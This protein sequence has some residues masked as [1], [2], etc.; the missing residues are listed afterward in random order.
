MNMRAIY[1]LFFSAMAATAAVFAAPEK[2]ASVPVYK[3]VSGDKLKVMVVG[4]SELGA[5]SQPIDLDGNVGLPH[6]TQPV[7]VAGLSAA[8]AEAAI[9][10]AYTKAAVVPDPKVQIN[11]AQ[12]APR[13]IP[14]AARLS[15]P[16]LS[17]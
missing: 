7:H 5:A 17:P 15:L 4:H 2:P 6:L 11:V 1:A 13:K 9:A 10:G 3:L 12:Y 8:E 16:R 14:A